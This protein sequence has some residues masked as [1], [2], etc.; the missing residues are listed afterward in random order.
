MKKD[1]Q[2][3][4]FSCLTY[5]QF[6]RLGDAPAPLKRYPDV[7]MPFHRI[8]IDIIG[9]MGDS[10]RIYKYCLVVINVL[11]RYLIAEKLKTKEATEVAKTFVDRV[12][13]CV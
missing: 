2:E 4:C 13:W 10:E 1:V 3:F 9:P 8:H 6:K 12:I 11:T 7:E 5:R